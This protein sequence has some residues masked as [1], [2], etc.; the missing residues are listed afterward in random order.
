V[1]SDLLWPTY[2]IIPQIKGVLKM[3]LQHQSFEVVNHSL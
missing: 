1:S 2:F 3:L